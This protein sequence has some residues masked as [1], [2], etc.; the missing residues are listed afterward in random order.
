MKKFVFKFDNVMDF[1]NQSLENKKGEHG[2]AIQMVNDQKEKINLLYKRFN[3]INSQFNEKKILGLT[4][5]EA[6]EYTSYLYKL[7][8]DIQVENVYLN[9]YISIE[10]QRRKEVV[11][12]KIETSTLEKLKEK[13]LN[14]YIKESQ[15][16]EE[17][18]IE[19]F[20]MRQRVTN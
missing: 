14:D 11:E 1:K 6:L 9:D 13:N 4:A 15:K 5:I 7:E 18:F 19:E 2:K 3:E 12:M 10:E 16:H 17:L 8:K 20:V